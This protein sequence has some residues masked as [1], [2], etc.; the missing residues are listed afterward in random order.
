[1]AE[2]SREGYEPEKIIAGILDIGELLLISGAEIMRVEDTISRLCQ[3]YGFAKADVFTITSSIVITA[4]TTE[5]HIF[6]QT[7]RIRTRDTDLGRVERVNALS[8][9][10]CA[11]PLPADKLK[12]AIEKVTVGKTYSKPTLL[13]LYG[14]IS[15]AFSVFFGGSLHDAFAAFISG[16]VLYGALE[17]GKILRLNGVLLNILCSGVTALA[18]VLICA[19]GIGE[20]PDKIIIGNIMLLIPGLALTSSLR[21]IINGDTISGL[22]GLSEALIKAFAIAI[23]SAAV[24]SSLGGLV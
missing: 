19:L 18:V 13:L 23:G 3:E 24:L 6:T 11:A 17:F 4:A 14:I 16:I 10:L 12:E 9:S 5:G 15:A 7:R 1:M 20:N 21:D 8:R 2:V 22:L